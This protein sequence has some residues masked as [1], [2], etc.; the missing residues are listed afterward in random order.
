MGQKITIVFDPETGKGEGNFF[1]I[2]NGIKVVNAIKALEYLA[3]WIR[4]GS[5]KHA[6]LNGMGKDTPYELKSAFLANQT[7]EEVL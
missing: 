7:V 5:E 1:Q 4:K 3:N 2:D 6:E